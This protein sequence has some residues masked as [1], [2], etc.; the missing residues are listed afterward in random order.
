MCF[1]NRGG[2]DKSGCTM[3]SHGAGV[4]SGAED[5]AGVGSDGGG[6]SYSVSWGAILGNLALCIYAGA[7]AA[8]VGVGRR[9][10]ANQRIRL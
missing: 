10:R 5:A 1:E 7:G 2:R 3:I 9:R 6:A 4:A 8:S